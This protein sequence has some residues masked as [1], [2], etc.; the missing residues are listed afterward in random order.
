MVKRL[1][2]CLDTIISCFSGERTREAKK[3][4]QTPCDTVDYLRRGFSWRAEFVLKIKNRKSQP[5]SRFSASP[6]GPVAG[7]S[8]A[9]TNRPYILVGQGKLQGTH[10]SLAFC[11]MNVIDGAALLWFHSTLANISCFQIT[12]HILQRAKFVS[13]YRINVELHK[14]KELRGQLSCSQKLSKAMWSKKRFMQGIL[15]FTV[16]AVVAFFTFPLR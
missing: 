14:W 1:R 8:W 9:K 13:T 3:S 4:R 10:K 7:S 5:Q 2:A 11:Y 12:V 16:P 6:R 15:S